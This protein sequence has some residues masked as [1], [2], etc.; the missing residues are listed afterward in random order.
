M[1]NETAQNSLGTQQ[2]L[3]EFLVEYVPAREPT[4]CA[5][6]TS[7]SGDLPLQHA[8]RYNALETEAIPLPMRN[9]YSSMETHE[10]IW[11]RS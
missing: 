6:Q 8:G 2:T 10:F 4:L 5:A 9:S 1:V 3:L 7:S 11:L